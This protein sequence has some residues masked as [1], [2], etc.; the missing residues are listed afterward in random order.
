MVD[1]K[2]V[3]GS[4]QFGMDYG[5]NNPKGKISENEV[6]M[7]LEKAYDSGI[8][9]IDTACSYGDSEKII[10]KFQK[11]KNKYFKIISKL[12]KCS[13]ADAPRYLQQSLSDLNNRS[14][15][16]YMIHDF[17]SYVRD[18][19]LLKYLENIKYEKIVE[20]IGFSIYYPREVEH[21]IRNNIAID[22]IQIPFSVLDQRFLPFLPEIR[23]RG[24]KIFA[25]S[26][27]LQGLVFKKNRDLHNRF[28]NI[29]DHLRKLE[30]ISLE[31]GI[32]IYSLCFNFALLNDYVDR[33]VVGVDNLEHFE[34][35]FLASNNVNEVNKLIPELSKLK[36][37][38]ENILLPF[39]WQEGQAK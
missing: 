6:K 16:G 22:F 7:I 32:P 26:I 21:L 13:I 31:S 28:K 18:H 17:E 3:L 34:K 4:A 9:T 20:N 35:L 37:E 10:G 11:N 2:I 29:S 8:N 19:N 23:S 25:R 24:I 12:P 14:I 30:L 33:I 1:N 15:Y 38:D 27:F 5:I 36:S 39:K